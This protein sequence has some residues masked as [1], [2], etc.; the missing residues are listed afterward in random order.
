MLEGLHPLPPRHYTL[1]VTHAGNFRFYFAGKI[2]HSCA[3]AMKTAS[4]Y[5]RVI[6]KV[7]KNQVFSAI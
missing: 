1:L 7:K 4:V 6:C 3:C 5:R 2:V